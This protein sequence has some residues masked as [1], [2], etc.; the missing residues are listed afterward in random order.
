[1]KKT[2]EKKM[3]LLSVLFP[4]M[5]FKDG[6]EFR[7]DGSNSI[8]TGEG[9]FIQDEHGREQY[10]FDHYGYHDTM[11]VNP[12][13]NKALNNLN[14]YAEFYDAGTVFIYPQ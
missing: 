6:G 5:W 3:K 1:M 8:W 4:Q 14:L 7:N 10:A 11:G 2:M 12:I 9:S 13:L